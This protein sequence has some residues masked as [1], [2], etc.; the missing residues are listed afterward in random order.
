VVSEVFHFLVDTATKAIQDGLSEQ[1]TITIKGMFT[2][3]DPSK[4]L[5][6]TDEQLK[7]LRRKALKAATAFGLP[8]DKSAALADAIAIQFR[9]G[10]L[11]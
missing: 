8:R 10:P 1:V 9:R 5:T 11:N 3:H 4:R 7:V 6:L 2:R